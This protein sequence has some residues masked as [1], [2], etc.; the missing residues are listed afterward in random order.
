LTY[1]VYSIIEEKFGYVFEEDSFIKERNVLI[2]FYFHILKYN[3]SL[4][5]CEIGFFEEKS[6]SLLL[7][8]KN[9]PIFLFFNFNLNFDLIFF[10]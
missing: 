2:N 8:N 6:E 3:Y 7:R 5:V 10:Y 4:T 1:I 9:L